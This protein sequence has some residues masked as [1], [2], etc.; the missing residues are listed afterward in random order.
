MAFDQSGLVVDI[1]EF[2]QCL[3]QLFDGPTRCLSHSRFSFKVRMKRSAH[4]L[5]SSGADKGRRRG[6]PCPSD[7][8][9]EVAADVLRSVVMAD[10][11]PRRH[12]LVDGSEALPYPLANR[13]Q[14]FEARAS[15]GRVLH[16]RNSP[17]NG[18]PPRTRRPA[19]RSR[20]GS[21]SCPC[22]TSHRPLN[23][24]W[25]HHEP[26]DH[27]VA[28]GIAWRANRSRASVA[29]PALITLGRGKGQIVARV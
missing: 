8:V 6:D 10:G 2:L 1:L 18:R 17:N 23:A 27:A 24:R 16:P 11:Q 22:P 4:P 12:S 20:E 26:E 7:L 9:L 21:L 28:L 5:P 29:I 14:R 15:R 19:A 25:F 3:L 13:F